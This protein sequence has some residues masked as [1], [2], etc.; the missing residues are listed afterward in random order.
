MIIPL[1]TFVVLFSGIL[2]AYWYFVVRPEE[3]ASS[4]LK[5]RLRKG[6][7][8][9]GRQ[10]SRL[11][12][13]TRSM[14]AVG[15][16]DAL[17]QR[18]R[19]PLAGLQQTIDQSG[20]RVTLGTVLLASGTLALLAFISVE[21]LAAAPLQKATGGVLAALALG[22][23]A[24]CLAAYI[25][26][27]VIRFAQVRRM[28]KFEEQF[29]EALDL[30]ARALRAGHAFTTGIEMVATEMPQ[31]VGPEFRLLYDQQN[32]GMPLPDCLRVFA[33]RIPVLDAR[34]FVTAVLIQRESGG[35]LSEVLDN[36]ATVIRD[37]FRVKRQM[38]VISA[39]GRITGWILVA[40]PPALGV[41]LMAANAEHRR[42]MFSD[43]LGIQMI[44]G[45]LVLQMIGTLI[46]RKIVNVEY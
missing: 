23:L 2:G 36:L 16:L 46:I 26:I 17:L 22:A 44:V 13:Q 25:P 7:S 5:R 15:P 40:L 1:L 12:K 20:V 39:H 37:R 19:A 14:S 34:F 3:I 11:L 41:V 9:P 29:P 38:R 43:P 35:N 6:H 21:R 31:P 8:A 42:T 45:A 10:S 28:R 27:A 30:L 33:E 32:Y 18:S 24:A 4:E